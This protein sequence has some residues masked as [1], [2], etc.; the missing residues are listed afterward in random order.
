MT[1]FSTL[2]SRFSIHNFYDLALSCWPH[3]LHS[4]LFLSIFLFNPHNWGLF[5]LMILWL[6]LGL[7]DHHYLFPFVVL[8]WNLGCIDRVFRCAYKHALVLMIRVW[9][10]VYFGVIKV[11]HIGSRIAS[12]LIASHCVVILIL[13]LR[14]PL[15]LFS[16]IA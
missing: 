4:W 14:S 6:G 11:A 3:H 9:I 10:R 12:I 15:I 2:H 16:I 13:S 7:R 1:T 5:P 8:I